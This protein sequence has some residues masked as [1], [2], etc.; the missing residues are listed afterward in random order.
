MLEVHTPVA[1]RLAL[2]QAWARR[3]LAEANGEGG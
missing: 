2:L 1:I 3:V